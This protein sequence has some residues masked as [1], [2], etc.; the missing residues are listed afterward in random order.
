MKIRKSSLLFFLRVPQALS[1]SQQQWKMSYE[2][3][4]IWTDDDPESVGAVATTHKRPKWSSS[5]VW[6]GKACDFSVSHT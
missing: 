3:I 6:N 1:E 2:A 5:Y 4:G